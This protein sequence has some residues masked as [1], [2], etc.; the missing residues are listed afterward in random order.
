MDIIDTDES[1]IDVMSKAIR[2]G[3]ICQ[4]NPNQVSSQLKSF[5][6]SNEKEIEMKPL[7]QS[8]H[9]RTP[10][11]WSDDGREL[12][13]LDCCDSQDYPTSSYDQFIILVKRMLKQ[14]TRN[15]VNRL[16]RQQCI[17]F[18]CN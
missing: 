16:R 2:N 7:L 10:S 9:A 1:T 15:T 17:D 14:T 4:F 11:K 8:I 3:K 13:K 18:Q 6:I 12:K 5:T